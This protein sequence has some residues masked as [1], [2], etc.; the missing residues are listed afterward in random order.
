M[1]W[2][3]TFDAESKSAKTPKSHFWEGGGGEIGIQLRIRI[4]CE[5]QQACNK[6]VMAYGKHLEQKI[7]M[8]IFLDMEKHRQFTLNNLKCV[9]TQGI[10]LNKRKRSF[11]N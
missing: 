6:V 11:K 1:G 2:N 10:Y 4:I 7:W 5:P 8:F 3:P 9:F